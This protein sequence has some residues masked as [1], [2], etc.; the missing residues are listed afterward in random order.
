[1]IYCINYAKMVISG[2]NKDFYDHVY[3]REITGLNMDFYD[4]IYNSFHYVF[5]K[6]D[7]YM[8]NIV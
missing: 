2:L 5:L 6:S 3:K 4:N 7:R 1:M 8:N